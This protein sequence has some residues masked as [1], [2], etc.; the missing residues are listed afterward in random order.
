VGAELLSQ[1]DR[2]NDSLSGLFNGSGHR[3]EGLT[4]I[5]FGG[6]L[7]SNKRLQMNISLTPEL[8]SQVRLKVDSGLY[9][10]ASALVEESLQLL[11]KRDAMRQHLIAEVTLGAVQLEQGEGISV[12]TEDEF[13]NLAR[14][15]R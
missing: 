8:E 15:T 5:G 6:I 10:S 4:P 13:L 11:L 12:N 7:K 1:R 9:Q 14:A 3:S 2:F